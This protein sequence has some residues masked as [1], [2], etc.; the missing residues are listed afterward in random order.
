[1]TIPQA[2]LI[3][4]AIYDTLA[5]VSRTGRLTLGDRYALMVATLDESVVEE[6]KQVMD[7]ILQWI[8]AGKIEV[9]DSF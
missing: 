7:R 8:L 6:E 5:T 2:S 1:M 4:G 9:S 3:P